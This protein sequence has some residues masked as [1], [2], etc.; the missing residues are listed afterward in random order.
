MTVTPLSAPLPPHPALEAD[1]L[2]PQGV[3]RRLGAPPLPRA[4]AGPARGLGWIA[5]AV[6]D[7]ARDPL[8]PPGLLILLETV[9]LAVT[10]VA[11]ASWPASS[12]GPLPTMDSGASLGARFREGRCGGSSPSRR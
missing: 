11:T 6:L 8:I 1:L 3:A 12:A 9:M 10:L 7:A 5:S 4:P 2:R